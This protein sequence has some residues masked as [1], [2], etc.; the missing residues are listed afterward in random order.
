MLNREK[1]IKE[2]SDIVCDGKNV[3]VVDGR[4]RRCEETPCGMCELRGGCNTKLG[5]W[6]NS[7]YV[8]LQVDWS[9][10]PIDTPVL[11]RDSEEKEWTHAHFA[12]YDEKCGVR[13]WAYGATSWSVA[14]SPHRTVAWNYAKLAESEG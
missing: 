3:A 10:V 2:I 14:K 4:P 8:E 11:V 13:T 1:F 9:K 5:K 7:E 6:A 12:G